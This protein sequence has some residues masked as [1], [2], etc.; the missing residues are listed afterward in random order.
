MKANYLEDLRSLL[1]NYKMEQTEKD[2]I[3]SDYN[4]MYEGYEGK[5][6]QDDEIVKK[7]GAPRSIIRELTEGFKKV[8]KPLPGGEKIIALSPFAALIIFFVLGF[9]FNLWHPGW[10]IFTIVPVTAIIVEMG[11]TRDEQLTTALS[12]FFASLLYLY[13]GFY[14]DLW[15]PGWIIFIIIPMLGIWNSRRTLSKLDLIVSLSPFL[16]GIAYVALGLQGYWKEG[17][18][19]FLIIPMLGLLNEKN[20]L[21]MLLW[22]LLFIAGIAGYLYVGYTYPE[23]WAYG[24]F[25]FA[26][27]VILGMITGNIEIVGGDI[28][29]EYN[30]IIVASTAVFLLLGFIFNLWGVAWLVFLVIPVYAINVEAPKSDRVVATTPFIALTIFFILGF[31]FGLWAYSWLAFLIIP[32][33]AIMKNA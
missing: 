33:V 13:L 15:H 30:I 21:M 20:R 17:W 12:P 2:E 31:F 1:N 23:Y 27:I 8:E 24:L 29:K 11:K 32:I 6:M 14:H 22:E 4:E 19:V 28:P 16:A 18:V 25:A 7:L 3:V 9:G 5:G 10:I 26:P